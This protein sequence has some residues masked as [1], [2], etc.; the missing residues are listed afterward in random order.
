VF[1]SARERSFAERKATICRGYFCVIPKRLP[2]PKESPSDRNILEAAPRNPPLSR[3]R[4]KMSE[5]Q[6][7]QK[8]VL[9][10]SLE[11]MEAIRRAAAS[12]GF[13][14]D[15]VAVWARQNVV[16]RA[17]SQIGENE[18]RAASTD[19][20]SQAK[21]ES[22]LGLGPCRCGYSNDPAGE[23]DGSCIMRY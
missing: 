10:V 7:S 20:A 9:P 21:P 22:S 19:I 4:L 23:C 6:R 3:Q 13:A 8:L 15:D 2:D 5:S 18:P 16:E 11:E 17:R 12:D 14:P 1:R